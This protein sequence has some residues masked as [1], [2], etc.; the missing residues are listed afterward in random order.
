MIKPIG[1]LSLLA[2]ITSISYCQSVSEPT[3]YLETVDSY[4]LPGEAPFQYVLA[5]QVSLRKAPST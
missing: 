1:L 4:Y 5:D 3:F 2:L